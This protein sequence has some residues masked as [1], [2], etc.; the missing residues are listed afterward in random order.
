MKKIISGI[1]IATSLSLFSCSEWVNVSS[2]QEIEADEMFNNEIGFQ[3]AQIGLYTRMTIE[4]TYGKDMTFGK[5]EELVQRYDNYGSNV[6]TDRE[7][8]KRY[9]YKNNDDA[10]DMVNSLWTE[11]FRTIA[12]ANELLERLEGKGKEIV[13]AELW[14]TL[15]GEALGLRAYHYFD[16]LRLYGPI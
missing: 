1:C 6:P 10:K 14:K 2:K 9:D 15:K 11:L 4:K 3:Q 16:L 13:N 5:I 8:A 7:R 12:N